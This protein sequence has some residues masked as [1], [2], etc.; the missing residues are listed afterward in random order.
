MKPQMGRFA[1]DAQPVAVLSGHHR[2]GR[3]L[4]DFLQ[5]R[6]GSAREQPRHVRFFRVAG[7]ARLDH[8]LQ[9]FEYVPHL[10][11]ISFR[12]LI[13]GSTA[14]QPPLSSLWKKQLC[15]PVWQAIPPP[16]STLSS[17]TSSCQSS[18]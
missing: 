5:D 14:T 1:D 8:V 7:L 18:P 2:L 13:P 3:F 17:T 4:A 10:P 6:V 12:S 15:L 16:Y 11:Y 9:P